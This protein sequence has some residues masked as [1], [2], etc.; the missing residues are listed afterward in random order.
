[1]SPRT[2]AVIALAASICLPLLALSPQAA[3]PKGSPYTLATCPVSGK[4]L[5]AQP[6]ILIYS[7]P[8][9]P[10]DD[11]REIRLCCPNCV[12]AFEKDPKAILSKVDA[13]MVEQQLSY[14]PAGNCLVMA[15]EALSDPR[16][17]DA[18]DDKNVIVRNQLVRL[19]CGKCVRKVTA[20]PDRFVAMV[21][22][23][24]IAAQSK[25]YPLATCPISGSAIDGKGH[26]FVI[27]SRLV[28]T[29]CPKC[30]AA[31]R[32]DPLPTLA[33]IDAA[34][35]AKGAAAPG[36]AASAPA[37]PAPAAPADSGKAAQPPAKPKGSAS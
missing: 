27:A 16:G 26:E 2:A 9:D 24:V 1:M 33:K 31:V 20:D 7:N 3:K 11:G 14:Y 12:G 22:R 15:D 36:N 6:H 34:A 8:N 18:K 30:E 19:C 35:K 29:C 13:A 32:A 4:P 5:P 21:D 28:R 23:S 37:K 10:I 25:D 17:P